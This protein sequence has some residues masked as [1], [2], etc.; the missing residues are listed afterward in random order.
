MKF[1]MAFLHGKKIYDTI[2]NSRT[3]EGHSENKEKIMVLADNSSI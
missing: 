2:K 3:D 1:Q